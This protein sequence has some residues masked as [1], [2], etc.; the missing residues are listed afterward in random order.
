MTGEVLSHYR[1][2]GTLGSGGMGVVYEALDLRLQRRV[3][4]KFLPQD[5]AQDTAARARFQREALAASA[6]NHPNICTIYEIDEAD[7]IVFMAMELLEG[8][9]FK[10][11]G[12]RK[13]LALEQLLEIGIQVADGLDAAHCEGIIHRDIKP[14]NLFLNK[15]GHAKILD[16]GLAKMTGTGGRKPL[17]DIE[18]THAVSHREAED[19]ELTRRG[20]VMG[21][22][23]YMSPEQ[24]AGRHLDARTDIFS[25]G[26]VLYLLATGAE[27]FTGNTW[28]EARNAILLNDPRLPSSL[29]PRLT[30]KFDDLLL[31]TLEKDRELRCQTAAELRADLKRLQREL[32]L[33]R[34]MPAHGERPSDSA[35]LIAA[36]TAAGGSLPESAT[37]TSVAGS[38][39][40]EIEGDSFGTPRTLAVLPLVNM[41]PEP[42]NEYLCD[43][44]AEELIN[45][46][47]QIEDLRVVSRSS[48]FQCKS[49]APDMREIGRKLRCSL[50]VSGSVRRAGD[51]L[52]LTVQLNDSRE[53]Y[54]IW[55]QRFDAQLRDI[56]SLQDELTMAVLDKL[57]QQIGSRIGSSDPIRRET[58][59]SGAYDLYL[60]ARFA[61]NLE[62]AGSLRQALDLYQRA[63][64][65]DP[66]FAPAMVGIAETHM[67]LEWYG[68]EPAAG[69]VAGAKSA[70][71]EALRL[72]PNS[73]PGL[74]QLAIILAASD[75]NWTA[76]GQ[77]F[78]KAL[79]FGGGH[80]SLHFHYALDYLTPLGRFDEALRE[81]RR[82]LELD[83]LSAITSTAI[84]GCYYR[85]RQW[86]AAARALRKT[87][88]AHPNFAHA[89]LSLG[90]ALLE[91][92]EN[93]EALHHF[94]EA[95][96]LQGRTASALA[97]LAYGF[98]RTGQQPRVTA[99]VAEVEVLSSRQPVAPVTWALVYT[100]LGD[101]QR[102]IGY[103]REAV[104]QRAHQAIWIGVDPR[105][106][107]LA[108]DPAFLELVSQLGLRP[109]KPAAQP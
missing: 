26:A 45:G 44:L 95:V 17:P 60:Q 56:F 81:I 66:A 3:A 100:A 106:D 24:A 72:E 71:D 98:S 97:E 50:V 54:Q 63:A 42:D 23:G 36:A 11:I 61:F 4:L 73:V 12:T 55:S 32:Q 79:A 14:S 58:A 7:G 104:Q 13:P 64:Q 82:G 30:G 21:T 91:L 31:K 6:L 69:A 10:Q 103:L 62:T 94:E 35:T 77:T 41:S 53:G 92:G 85:M 39:R 52:R 101:S 22:M 28:L 37:L 27:A 67:R 20:T 29:N 15:R 96:R 43:G 107:P 65:L 34:L 1:I 78:E 76:A 109:Q 33:G 70:L 40:A 102:A 68:L 51:R 75:W 80:A 90:R 87:L 86:S 88:Q 38:R 46:L 16:F 99:L 83:P 89:H 8:R 105:L 59:K 108:A 19:P 25:F 84:G 9:S 74:C 2:M 57:R 5:L 49:N 18:E 47:T 93:D 48:S